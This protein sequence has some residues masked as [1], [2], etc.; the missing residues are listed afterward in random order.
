MKVKVEYLQ[1]MDVDKALSSVTVDSSVTDDDE[2]D[3]YET[4]R[5]VSWPSL[6]CQ[7][8]YALSVEFWGF[9]SDFPSSGSIFH[10]GPISY[11]PQKRYIWISFVVIYKTLSYQQIYS[12]K[13]FF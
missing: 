1:V 5:I 2:D 11:V 13:T 6:S 12:E 8:L 9:Y 3:W 10:F 4:F 7:D